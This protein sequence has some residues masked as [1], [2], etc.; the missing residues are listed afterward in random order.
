MDR[1][2]WC[3]N[4]PRNYHALPGDGPLPSPF[5]VIGERPG[6]DENRYQR[7]F[8]GKIGQELNETYLPL[9][10][11]ARHDVRLCNTVR[12]WADNNRTPSDREI[13][14]CAQHHLANEIEQT[15]PDV[16]VLLGSSA[17][18]LFPGVQLERQHGIP[19]HTDKV[20]GLDKSLFG[21]RG[22]VVP[23]YHPALGLHESKWMVQMLEDW[24]RLGKVLSARVWDFDRPVTETDYRL[25]QEPEEV[26]NY[27]YQYLPNTTR[28]ARTAT[29]TAT[30][31]RNFAVD[32]EDHG[33]VPWSVQISCKP[34]T[35]IL[36]PAKNELACTVA[37]ELMHGSPITLHNAAHDLDVLRSMNIQVGEFRDTMQEAFHQG[38]L[39]QG[40]KSLVYRLFGY[41]MTSWEDVVRPDSIRLLL[42]WIGEGAMIAQTD[43]AYVERKQLK[44]KVKETVKAGAL[45]KLLVHLIKHTDVHS[46]YDPWERLKIFWS[47]ESNEWMTAYVEARIGKYPILGIANCSLPRAISYAVSDA[48]WTGQVARELKK[49]RERDG[50]YEINDNDCDQ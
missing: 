6:K 28:T 32:T 8:V 37:S 46:E 50:K 1:L 12:C 22:W 11:L 14:E 49:R 7:I 10:G 45:E 47:E 13:L 41:T 23:M 30:T 39:P 43:L 5:L 29:A 34:G 42:E 17:C 25:T 38:N 35:G 48:D 4:C 2:G 21:W 19:Q 24:E 16:V 44:T 20:G 9:A 18:K 27:F 40:L 36:I 31:V 15:A 26:L 3:P 33:G